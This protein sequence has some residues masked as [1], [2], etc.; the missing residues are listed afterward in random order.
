MSKIENA[1]RKSLFFTDNTTQDIKGRTTKDVRENKERY[2]VK[3]SSQG[4]SKVTIP[5]ATKMFSQIKKVVD[6]TEIPDNSK[7]IK[8][9][10]IKST[11][12]N[13]T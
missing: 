11:R 8:S 9:S 4:D 10:G 13:T 5:Q 3:D 7:K 1:S 2:M 12:E 6:S